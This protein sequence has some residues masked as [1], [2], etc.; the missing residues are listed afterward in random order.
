M[1]DPKMGHSRK[2]TYSLPEEISAIQR[3][4]GAK[5]VSENIKCISRGQVV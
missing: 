1:D 2:D 5:F 3:G 4:R